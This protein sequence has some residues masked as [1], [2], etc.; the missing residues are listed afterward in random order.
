MLQPACQPRTASPHFSYPFGESLQTSKRMRN[1]REGHS[2]I[3]ECHPEDDAAQADE[4][5]AQKAAFVVK[6]HPASKAD[7][8]QQNAL[9]LHR[10]RRH[11]S[12]TAPRHDLRR[13]SRQGSLGQ[14]SN[15]RL[16][17]RKSPFVM[18]GSITGIRSGASAEQ[19]T[20]GNQTEARTTTP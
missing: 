5:V 16:A 2:D 1:P 10:P 11:A 14:L 12:Y 17:Q 20:N 8:R 18:R 13:V 4:L 15:G 19:I 9:W 6:L 7:Q 3:Q